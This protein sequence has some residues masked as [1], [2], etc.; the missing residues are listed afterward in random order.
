MYLSQSFPDKIELDDGWL[1]TDDPYATVRIFPT[2][3]EG[4]DL[5]KYYF[6]I[7]AELVDGVKDTPFLQKYLSLMNSSYH[8][9]KITLLKSGK[10]LAVYSVVTIPA[11]DLQQKEVLFALFVTGGLIENL[12]DRIRHAIKTKSLD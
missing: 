11:D 6:S 1:L 12:P 2:G 5:P 9:A 4:D 7:E 3:F 10:N 8:Y